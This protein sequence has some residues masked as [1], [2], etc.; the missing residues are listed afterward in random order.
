MPGQKE[1]LVPETIPI[2][3][4]ELLRG[5]GVHRVKLPIK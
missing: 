4:P 1:R 2:F 3:Y 5:T